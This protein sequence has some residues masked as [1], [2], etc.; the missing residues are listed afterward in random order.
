[1]RSSIALLLL[2]LVVAAASSA[3]KA[4]NAPNGLRYDAQ[5]EAIVIHNGTNFN[6]RPLYCKHTPVFTLGGDRP[7][8]LFAGGH[9]ING[10]FMLALVRGND[11]LW[12]QEA[13]SVV[14]RYQGGGME[15]EVKDARFGETMVRLRAVP[16]ADAPGFA[17]HVSVEGAKPGDQIVWAYGAAR[18]LPASGPR[19][20]SWGLDPLGHPEMLTQGFA[21][22]GCQ[23]D[24]VTLDGD[25]FILHP[26]AYEAKENVPMQTVAGRCSVP[27][28]LRISDSKQ[29]RNPVALSNSE[30][31]AQPIVSGVISLD[32]QKEAFWAVRSFPGPKTGDTALMKSPREAF[33]LGQKR[34]GD[35]ARTVV[36]DTP[37]ARL[38]ALAAASCVAMDAVWYPPVFVHGAMQWN[39]SLLGWRT[40]FGGICYGWHDRVKTQAA[41]CLERQVKSSEKLLPKANPK[42]GYSSQSDESRLFGKG[43]VDAFH[44]HHY[45]MQS[46][47]FDQVLH[48]WR[49][50]ADPELER[51]LRPALEL[52]LEWMKDCFDPDDDGVY[53]SYIN[54]W[55]TDSQWYNGAGTAEETAYAYRGHKAAMDLARRAGDTRA[56]ARHRAQL[57]KIRRGFFQQLWIPRKG[58]VGA[59]REQMGYRRLNEN[60]WLYS[61]FLPIDAGLLT[62]LQAAQALH[63]TE[64]GLQNDQMPCGGRRVWT[65]NWV[66][67]LWSVREMWPGDNYHL[68]LAYFQTGLPADGWDIFKGT[69]LESAYA[70]PVPGNLG[71]AVGGVDFNDCSSM[72]CRA[73]VEGLFGYEPDYPRGTVTL[74]PQFPAQWDHASI[75]TPDFALNFT[76]GRENLRCVVELTQAAA[77]EA[78]L[79]VAARRV[80]QVAVNGKS[81]KWEVLPG[82]GASIVCVRVPHT[83]RVDISVSFAE[84]EPALGAQ[85][86]DLGAGQRVEWTALQGQLMRFEDPQGVLTNTVIRAGKLTGTVTGNAGHHL[87]FGLAQNGKLEQWQTFKVTVTDQE[88]DAA[89]AAKRARDI[90]AGARWDCLDISKAFNGDVRAIYEQ[91]Y[92]SPRP[93]TVSARIGSDGYA[94]WTFYAWGYQRPVI[95]LDNIPKLLG[96]AGKIRTPQN[97][98][99]V[100]HEGGTNIAFTSQWDNWPGHVTVPVGKKGD[101][102]WLLICGS[103]NPMQCG[104]ANAEVRMRYADGVVEKLELV[105][106]DNYWT[107]CP[108]NVN[109]T[110][111]GQPSRGEYNYERDGFCLPNPPPMTVQ[112][113]ENCRANLLSWRLRPGV[114]LEDLTL[115][116][117]SQEVVV[118]LMGITLMN[119][120]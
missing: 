102:I 96:D 111:P 76:R 10:N 71:E 59:Y 45:D 94:P 98:P 53:E 43:Y 70:G 67:S 112:L 28:Q 48:D 27:T 91:Q 64:W 117:L 24:T 52:H 26:P 58:Y 72:F 73:L 109:P 89:R 39:S 34:I 86:A 5:G 30:S 120:R 69:F 82:L 78:R 12:I 113:G 100:W 107:L 66:P 2:P 29:W 119:P 33:E 21:P 31:G 23:G 81:V 18:H 108:I 61:I 25:L 9:Y 11:G 115:E 56:E 110:G 38:N 47:F 93:Q 104:I 41:Y 103:S 77:L 44:P 13:S 50:T 92:L 101:A 60:P 62:P 80:R 14:A 99:F 16:L 75:R 1:M 55:P 88:A 74:R 46:Q 85:V 35:V 40:L 19:N 84:P 15:W 36:V 105:H 87:V 68:A 90:P 65:S 42:A 95:K 118:G 7:F 49:Y 57:E 22:E 79:P 83:R 54:T 32:G 116:T 114:A 51:I 37:D 106:P 6:N 63:F 97:V 17:A 3:T 8:L 20:A 4:G